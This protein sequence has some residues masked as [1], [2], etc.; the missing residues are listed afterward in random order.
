M[1]LLSPLLTR[2]LR[3]K[4]P[5]FIFFDEIAFMMLFCIGMCFLYCGG[6]GLWWVVVVILP[7][8]SLQK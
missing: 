7:N 8:K 2:F 4:A 5:F 1:A 3:M 6:C